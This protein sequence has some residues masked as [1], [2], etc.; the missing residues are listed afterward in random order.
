[1]KVEV[2]KNLHKGCWSVR[3]KGKVVD[4]A[5]IVFLRDA[6]F[7][8][9]PG[10]RKRVLEEQRKNVHAWVKGERIERPPRNLKFESVAMY[11]PY[12]YETFVNI[13]KEPIREAKYVAMLHGKVYIGDIHGE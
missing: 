1:M 13:M 2:Y 10:G 3:H 5:D 11:N 12:K 8:V 7:V 9:Q 6:K 4:Y